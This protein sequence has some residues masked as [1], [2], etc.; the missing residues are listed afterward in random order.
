MSEH[1]HGLDHENEER[2]QA[3]KRVTLIGAAANAVLAAGKVGV[4]YL[5]NS[6]AL[7]ADGIHSLSDLLTDGLVLYGAHHGSRKADADHPYGHA[8]IETLVTTLLGLALILVAAGLAWDAGRALVAAEELSP[9]GILALWAAAASILI[10]EALYHYTARVARRVR[11]QLLR[12][13]AWH[14]RSDAISSVV[15]VIGVGG[16]LLGFPMLDAVAAIAVAVM[17]AAVGAKLAWG[18]LRELIDTGLEDARL[19]V[20]RETIQDVDGVRDLHL[21]RTR[22]MGPHALV[23]VHIIVEPRISIS[24]GHYISELVAHRLVERVDEV[25]DVLVHIDPEDDQINPSPHGLPSRARLHQEL[26]AAWADCPGA[27][28]ITDSDLRIHYLAGGIELELTLPLDLLEGRDAEALE[29]AYGSCLPRMEAI[30]SLRLLFA[31][32]RAPE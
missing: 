13:N 23:D 27:R 21:L 11:S 7:I 20:I 4:G 2:Y 28:G 19:A 22:R 26:A 17:V 8:R 3:S 14:H 31:P 25:S 5:A 29:A 9:P 12:A 18:S 16:A 15:V 30:R 10:K 1:V 6:H 32:P 24:E